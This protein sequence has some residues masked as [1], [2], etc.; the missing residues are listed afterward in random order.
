MAR[1]RSP[2]RLR[3]LRSG[4]LT[5]LYVVGVGVAFGQAPTPPTLTAPYRH[6]LLGVYDG[7]TGEAIEGAEVTDAFNHVSALT[8]K[9][10]TVT[11]VFLPDGGSLVQIK[12]IGYQPVT[13]LVQI[14]PAD[15]V[16]V[17]VTLNP[18]VQTLP[19]VVTNDSSPH[20]I[21]PGLRG[22]EERRK[23]GFGHFLTEAELR[24]NDSGRMSDMIRRF[25]GLAITCA[26]T[27]PRRGDCWAVS[28]RLA[29]KYAIQGGSCDVDVYLDGALSTNNDL[30]KLNVNE[31]AGVEYYSGGA[32]IPVQYNKTGSS[33]G[34][35][36]LWHRER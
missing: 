24:K 30:E 16:P 28:T 18:A 26:K 8:T 35:L 10:G 7:A 12:K 17:T 36:L 31:F 19:A 13:M 2:T 15:T 22:F 21:S 32:T 9:T 25:S 14:S 11:L 27:G 5:I 34:V 23:L 1:S 3:L 4:L 33:C 6:R 29:S 20:F